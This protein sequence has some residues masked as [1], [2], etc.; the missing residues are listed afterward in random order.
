MEKKY[1]STVEVGKILGISREAVLKRVKT[2][3]LKSER[4][5][6]N[7]MIPRSEMESLVDG[8]LDEGRKKEIQEAVKRVVKEYGQTLKLLGKE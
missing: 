3:T 7:F 1:F 2:G 4:F 5:G 8:V 6:R